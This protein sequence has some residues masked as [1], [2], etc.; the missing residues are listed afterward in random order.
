MASVSG[1]PR[2]PPQA[3]QAQARPQVQQWQVEIL[4]MFRPRLHV[5]T[6]GMLS[7]RRRTWSV[8]CGVCWQDMFPLTMLHGAWQWLVIQR[9]VNMRR[10]STILVFTGVFCVISGFIMRFCLRHQYEPYSHTT[11]RRGHGKA[12]DFS[13]CR[14]S[15][16]NPECCTGHFTAQLQ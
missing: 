9:P 11:V 3:R 8:S 4:L 16:Q 10:T 6:L 5:R 2:S 1:R 13:G 7:M 12:R 15:L 14:K